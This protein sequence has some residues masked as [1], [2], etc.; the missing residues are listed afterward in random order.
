MPAEE[1]RLYEEQ[2]EQDAKRYQLEKAAYDKENRLG[3]GL[4][5]GG[6]RAFETEMVEQLI[7]VWGKD[8]EKW[9]PQK[10]TLKAIKAFALWH[11]WTE[12]GFCDKKLMHFI[13]R[14]QVK[15]ATRAPEPSSSQAT[16]PT[17]SLGAESGESQHGADTPVL[18][19]TGAAANGLSEQEI[20]TYDLYTTR[21]NETLEDV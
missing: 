15:Y 11:R 21:N 2:S 7:G 17:V 19:L 9:R 4:G 16:P 14:L 5:G 8:V 18:T 12:A 13:Q 6:V 20:K 3:G 1:K 10:K